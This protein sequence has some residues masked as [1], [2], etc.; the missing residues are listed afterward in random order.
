MNRSKIKQTTCSINKTIHVF[1][2]QNFIYWM[3]DVEPVEEAIE[4]LGGEA[5]VFERCSK[6]CDYHSSTVGSL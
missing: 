5:W 6:G 4:A 1:L 2:I 3:I